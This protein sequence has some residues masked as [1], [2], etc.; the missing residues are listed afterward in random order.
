M[1][2]RKS[3]E[4]EPASHY[5]AVTLHANA[6]PHEP[7]L[8]GVRYNP[9]FLTSSGSLQGVTGMVFERQGGNQNS[10]LNCLPR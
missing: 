10:V 2:A 6:A 9:L 1:A 4:G 3:G 5:T 8:L 7:H